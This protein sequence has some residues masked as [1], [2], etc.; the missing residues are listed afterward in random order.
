MSSLNKSDPGS[1]LYEPG[2]FYITCKGML[3]ID[4]YVKLSIGYL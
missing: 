1:H 2:R 4:K 3:K